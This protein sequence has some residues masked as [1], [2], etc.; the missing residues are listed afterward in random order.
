MSATLN[1]TPDARV[2]GV[3]KMRKPEGDEP[4]PQARFHHD[5]VAK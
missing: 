2:G 5:E 3:A 4:L 1:T